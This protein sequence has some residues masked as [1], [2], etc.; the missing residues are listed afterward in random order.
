MPPKPPS[1]QPNPQHGLPSLCSCSA[2]KLRLQFCPPSPPSLLL[3][4]PHP[5]LQSLCSRSTLN[6]PYASSHPPNPLRRLPFLRS[7]IRFI[8]YGGLLAYMMNAITEIC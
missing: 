3:T 5:R 1:N 6:P 8:G 2:L 7:C 4:I